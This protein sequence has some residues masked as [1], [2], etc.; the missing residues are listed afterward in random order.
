MHIIVITIT[1]KRRTIRES[2][3]GIR[4]ACMHAPPSTSRSPAVRPRPI[5]EVVIRVVREDLVV[6]VVCLHLLCLN[7]RQDLLQR[8]L[9][10]R[11]LLGLL[12]C[13]GLRERAVKGKLHERIVGS[14]VVVLVPHPVRDVWI[15][16]G[17]DLLPR[18]EDG[19]FHQLLR[20]QGRGTSA[21]AGSGARGIGACDVGARSIGARGIGAR[22]AGPE[23]VLEIR[24]AGAAD[25]HRGPQVQVLLPGLA[26][27]QLPRRPS[28]GHGAE[29]Q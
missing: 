11:L 14:C 10:P 17:E 26:V 13:G 8:G 3:G 28:S 12:C 23:A 4:K 22:S 5:V 20:T 27:E 18:V 21:S 25:A 7:L 6:V 19:A 9:L 2:A 24:L 29:E 1:T 16:D 15:D